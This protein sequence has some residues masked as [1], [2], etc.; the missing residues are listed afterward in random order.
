MAIVE[1]VADTAGM[2]GGRSV[3]GASPRAAGTGGRRPAWRRLVVPAITVAFAVCF[4]PS[5][6]VAFERDEGEYAHAADLLLAGGVPY[7]DAFLQKPPAIILAYAS[8]LAWTPDGTAAIHAVGLASL[9]A[10]IPLLA[11]AV[12]ALG[13]EAAAIGAALLAALALLSPVNEPHPANTEVFLLPWATAAYA[14]FAVAARRSRTGGA[15]VG[16]RAAAG[17]GLCLGLAAL[18]KQ[19][20][21]FHAPHLL[22]GW[23]LVARRGPRRGVPAAAFAVAAIAPWLAVA[24]WFAARGAL[25]PFAEGVLLHN[26]RYVSFNPEGAPAVLL[27]ARIDAMS[28]FDRALWLAAFAGAAAILAVGSR[29]VAFVAVGWLATALAGVSSGGYFR[30]HYL[31]QAVPA[32][33]ACAALAGARLP[34]AVGAT[35]LAVLA[36]LWAGGAP[37]L[38][39]VDP[40]EQSFRHYGGLRFAN[41]PAIGRLLRRE[42]A[43]DPGARLFVMGSE[44][45]ILHASGLRAATR[46]VILSPLTGGYPGG[47]ELQEEVWREVSG[48]PPEFIVVS[49]PAAVPLFRHSETTLYERVARLVRER[50]RPIAKTSAVHLGLLPP[51]PGVPDGF[52]PDLW[53]YRRVEDGTAPASAPIDLPPSG[54]LRDLLLPGRPERVSR[55]GE[56]A[57]D[58]AR[59]WNTR[60]TSS[61]C[62]SA[63]TSLS[64]SVALSSGRVMPVC[65]T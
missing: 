33:A 47:H 2:D 23:W 9:A 63:S 48:S 32:L 17:S 50:Y 24:A 40:A 18:F 10:T 20:A 61:S 27:A 53:V 11:V 28:A 16:A 15:A 5:L 59:L 43:G 58:Q 34:R 30:G 39:G 29:G 62:S 41:S 14:L 37:L 46:W 54:D 8:V 21:V 57:G 31:L 1:Q 51:G 45:Q 22:L 38:F 4:A 44:P 25:G 42:S 7:R 13:G 65:A 35:A 56:P 26:L 55:A 3:A 60:C 19:V 6:P 36:A 49:V 64:T 52:V 12:G